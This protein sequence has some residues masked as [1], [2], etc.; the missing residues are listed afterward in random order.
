MLDLPTFTEVCRGALLGHSVGTVTLEPYVPAYDYHKCLELLGEYYA[1]SRQAT[2]HYLSDF[3]A[4]YHEAI[5]PVL[6]ETTEPQD[7]TNG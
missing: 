3:L 5:S 2:L 1:T 4:T 7:I 6:I